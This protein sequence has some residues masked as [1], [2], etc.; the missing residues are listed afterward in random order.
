MPASYG[1]SSKVTEALCESD[2]PSE[3]EYDGRKIM[4]VIES[5]IHSTNRS[6]LN[7]QFRLSLELIELLH[8]LLAPSRK[9]SELL[10][11]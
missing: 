1:S 2:L 8:V 6:V 7:P 9:V 5:G 10:L 4:F 11:E 3:C